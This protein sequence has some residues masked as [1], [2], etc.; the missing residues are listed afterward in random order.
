MTAELAYVDGKEDY[1]GFRIN[2]LEILRPIEATG[3]WTTGE[4]G[5]TLVDVMSPAT[6]AT[7]RRRG[8]GKVAGRRAYIFDYTVEQPNSHWTLI[9]PGGGQYN[10]AYE[11]AVWIDTETRRVLRIEARATGLPRS[12]K[13]TRA[14]STLE[15]GFV[16][17]EEATFLLPVGGEN[18]GCVRHATG[19]TRNVIEFRKY[20]KFTAESTLMIG[21]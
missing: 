4:F 15:Y 7:F 3:V 1:R 10:P 16:K 9:E 19:C 20:R 18:I 13:L 17:I 12:F 6:N 11:G 5:T 8:Q 21:K 2:G 14:E